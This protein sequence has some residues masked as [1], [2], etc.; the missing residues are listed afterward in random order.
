[1]RAYT[2]AQLAMLRRIAD[3]DGDALALAVAPSGSEEVARLQ[4]LISNDLVEEFDRFVPHDHPA[5]KPMAITQDMLR[6]KGVRI[7]DAG[8]KILEVKK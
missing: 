4:V 6:A 8:R 3:G 2:K 5:I 1:M 7:T